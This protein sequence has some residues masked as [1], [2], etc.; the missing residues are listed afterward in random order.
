MGKWKTSFPHPFLSHLIPVIGFQ[1]SQSLPSLFVSSMA[2]A[3]IVV[4]GG[5][6]QRGQDKD[7]GMHWFENAAAEPCPPPPF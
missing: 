4:Y 2:M 3:F 6:K 5:E 7:T 1:A